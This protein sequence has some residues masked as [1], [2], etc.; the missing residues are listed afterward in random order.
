MK[1]SGKNEILRRIISEVSRFTLHFLRAIIR[2]ISDYLFDSVGNGHSYRRL[3]FS[4]VLKK[5]HCCCR[6]LFC[7]VEDHSKL[8]GGLLLCFA[9][10]NVEVVDMARGG[11]PIIKL[12]HS[13]HMYC[14]HTHQHR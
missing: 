12:S 4:I 9:V 3:T 6:G 5:Q 1:C 7:S 13:T 11:E 2:K 8:F 14:T 10:V